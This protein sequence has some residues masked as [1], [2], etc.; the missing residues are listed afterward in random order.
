MSIRYLRLTTGEEIM[1]SV[2]EV[3]KKS[4]MLFNPLQIEYGELHEGVRLPFLS[5]YNPYGSTFEIK[6]DRC[7]VMMS[8]EMCPEAT[9][10]YKTSLEYCETVTDAIIHDRLIDADQYI[11]GNGYAG[12]ENPMVQMDSMFGQDDDDYS[13][14]TVNCIRPTT[15][16][17]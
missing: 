17:H 13:S 14:V 16:F 8:E 9:Q 10:Y 6:M 11:R 7:H 3:D 5:R 4:L 2:H 15:T 1:A 12:P